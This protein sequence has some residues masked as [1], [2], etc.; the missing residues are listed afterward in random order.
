[1]VKSIGQI[2]RAMELVAAAKM[3]R[4]QDSALAGR[5]Y[6]QAM[7]SML[8]QLLIRVNSA[9]YPLLQHSVESTE[10]PSR[11]LVVM[12]GPSKGLTGSLPFNLIREVS[13]F[14]SDNP[15]T[16]LITKGK[17][18]RDGV[19]KLHRNTELVADFPLKERPRLGD[20]LLM[21]K[22]VIEE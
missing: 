16:R 18:T 19:L 3:R 5:A 22:M 6:N 7:Y 14:I 8:Q 21:S 2:T 20:V 15:E 12:F 11:P 4:A 10:K 17:R 1:S 13:K 9:D